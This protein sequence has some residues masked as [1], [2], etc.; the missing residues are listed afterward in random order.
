MIGNG[1]FL[2]GFIMFATKIVDFSVLFWV[3]GFKSSDD[4]ILPMW[5]ILKLCS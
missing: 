3:I 4:I 2:E 1:T 5:D